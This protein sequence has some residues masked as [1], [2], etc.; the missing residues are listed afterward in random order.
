MEGVRA[1]RIVRS[2]DSWVGEN[3]CARQ[4]PK[5]DRKY[6]RKPTQKDSLPGELKKPI[7]QRTPGLMARVAVRSANG[8]GFPGRNSTSQTNDG[9]WVIL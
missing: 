5:N 3:A 6:Y 7:N 1:K 4:N 9:D 2:V 8:G